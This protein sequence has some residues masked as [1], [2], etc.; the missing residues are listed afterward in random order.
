MTSDIAKA[1]VTE[2]IEMG[3]DM[4]VSACP[5]CKSTLSTA[6][7]ELKKETGKKVKVKDIVEIVAKYTTAPE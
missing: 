4:I 7:L 6:A 5:A 2:A 1:R 3:A